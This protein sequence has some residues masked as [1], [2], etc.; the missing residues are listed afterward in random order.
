MLSSLAVFFFDK[1][2]KTA[3]YVGPLLLVCYTPQNDYSSEMQAM[4]IY[5]CVYVQTN[6]TPNS[7]QNSL[8]K[9]FWHFIHLEKIAFHHSK[10]VCRQRDEVFDYLNNTPSEVE[11]K[12]IIIFHMG[13]S[14]SDKIS[15]RVLVR[16]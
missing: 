4:Y 14:N 9:A 1:K 13:K 3:V 12:K 7:Q 16:E 15:V 6:C 10:R 2:T 5:T 8:G 11:R